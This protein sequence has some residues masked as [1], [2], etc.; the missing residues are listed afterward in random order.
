MR[1]ISHPRLTEC[2]LSSKE[3][4]I[5]PFVRNIYMV[6]TLVDEDLELVV[7][8]MSFDLSHGFNWG[9]KVAVLA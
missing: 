1:L 9:S 7:G 8:L 6:E 5:I 2:K 3:E 4:V